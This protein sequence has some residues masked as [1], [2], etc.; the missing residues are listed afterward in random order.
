MEKNF[1]SLQYESFLQ[2]L[3]VKRENARL[4][5]IPRVNAETGEITEVYVVRDITS[6][7]VLASV[8]R[9]LR[10]NSLK[11]TAANLSRAIEDGLLVVNTIDGIELPVLCLANS[12]AF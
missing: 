6:G 5:Y 7:K 8:S 12:I 4:N 11:E 3:G 2:G 9:K 1:N 10:G